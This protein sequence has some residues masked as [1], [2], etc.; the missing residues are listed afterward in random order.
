M[1]ISELR[2]C[3]YESSGKVSEII[4][5]LALA[6][7]ATI[8]ILKVGTDSGGIKYS[9]SLLCP[10]GVFVFC[11]GLDLLQYVYKTALFG[12]LNHHYWRK[13]R[14]NDKEIKFAEKWNW[15]ALFFFWLKTVMMVSGY[16]ML[17]RYIGAKLGELPE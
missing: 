6:G 2:D 11:L 4:R 12:F 13:H 8:W 15:P 1:K 5:Q 9:K 16:A 10:L 14:D 17:I 7:I 3:Y